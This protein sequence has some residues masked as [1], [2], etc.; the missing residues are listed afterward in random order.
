MNRSIIA[1]QA[2]NV[3]RINKHHTE[4]T[5]YPERIERKP[6]LL[7]ECQSARV[8]MGRFLRSFRNRRIRNQQNR[9]TH[10][11]RQMDRGIASTINLSV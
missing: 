5:N 10:S 4:G 1:A 2:V 11:S 3:P 8:V 6:L 9:S 7:V